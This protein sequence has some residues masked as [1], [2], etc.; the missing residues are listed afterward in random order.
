MLL[1][2]APWMQLTMHGFNLL[3]QF[4]IHTPFVKRMG[5]LEYFLNTPS[6]HRVHHGV[7]DIYIDRNYAG[8][9]IIWDRLFGALETASSDQVA[10]LG[11]EPDAKAGTVLITGDSLSYLAALSY[12]LNLS[13][14]DGLTGVQLVRHEAKANDLRGAV[15]FTVSAAWNGARK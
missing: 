12:V 6:H 15:G 3:H 9:L 14:V 10:L 13:Q 8:A 2:F 11:I 1:G 7:N 4:W 5:F